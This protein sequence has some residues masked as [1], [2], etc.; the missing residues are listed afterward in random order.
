[1]KRLEDFNTCSDNFH[2]GYT[3]FNRNF[4]IFSVIVWEHLLLQQIYRYV[5]NYNNSNTLLNFLGSSISIYLHLKKGLLKKL[6]DISFLN[7]GGE[8]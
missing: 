4:L 5:S 7:F 1:M 3:I 8:V 2:V 6:I